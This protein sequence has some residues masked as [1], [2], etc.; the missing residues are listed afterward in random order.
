MTKDSRR[1]RGPQP[2][3][4]ACAKEAATAN[5]GCQNQVG[6][7]S[8]YSR[9]QDDSRLDSRMDKWMERVDWI[10]VNSTCSGSRLN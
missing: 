7:I 1:L 10:G 6:Q 2:R 4:G 8:S 3:Q 5:E 9:Q